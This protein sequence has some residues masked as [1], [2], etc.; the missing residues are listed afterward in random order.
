[1]TT[2]FVVSLA[3]EALLTTILV[4]LPVLGVSVIVG[5]VISILQTVTGLQEPTLT[6]VPKIIA[7]LI[8]IGIFASWMLLTMMDYTI[9]LIDIMPTVAR[10]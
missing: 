4:S 10:G 8:T 9:R 7:M 5:L 6:F 1:M 2:D 3:Q